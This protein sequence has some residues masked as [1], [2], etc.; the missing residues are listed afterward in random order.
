MIN[1]SWFYND[2]IETDVEL[3]FYNENNKIGLIEVV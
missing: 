2:M 3:L 1:A